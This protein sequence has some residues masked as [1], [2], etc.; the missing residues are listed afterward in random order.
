MKNQNIDSLIRDEIVLT[1]DEIKRLREGVKELIAAKSESNEELPDISSFE[2]AF[3]NYGDSDIGL[4]TRIKQ[5]FDTSSS[6]TSSLSSSGSVLPSGVSD[7]YVSPTDSSIAK[8]LGEHGILNSLD[9]IKQNSLD[10]SNSNYSKLSQAVANLD[11]FVNKTIPKSFVS[12]ITHDDD[13]IFISAWRLLNKN[14]FN[15]PRGYQQL[16]EFS[17]NSLD[18]I[19]EN[20]VNLNLT[21]S[22]ISLVST[23]LTYRMILK[24]YTKCAY[25]TQTMGQDKLVMDTA[26]MTARAREVRFFA[27]VCAP[28]IVFPLY[29]IG[30]LVG[31]KLSVSVDTSPIFEGLASLSPAEG[32][33]LQ[34]DAASFSDMKSSSPPCGFLM[35]FR[36]INNKFKW[37][38][39]LLIFIS[40]IFIHINSTTQAI[41]AG[42]FYYL[43]LNMYW[44]KYVSIL[45]MYIW[46]VFYIL[47][48]IKY[49][50]F[51]EIKFDNPPKY[52]PRFILTRIEDFNKQSEIKED[53]EYYVKVYTR[54]VLFILGLSILQTFLILY[55]L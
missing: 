10:L 46:V 5:Y 11:S 37:L 7:V 1:P 12:K 22:T 42:I 15:P 43:H 20:A 50:F 34:S 31:P 8:F 54:T 14:D 48:L 13:N 3:P 38:K 17:K 35:F 19:K 28:M 36:N 24:A 16:L 18:L 2:E 6:H 49:R 25:P 55:F 47:I 23:A 52:L 40:F 45:W 9:I 30:C 32:S 33:S 27:L 53:Q 4:I 39:Y 29:T 51:F 21:A 44:I 41:L 26:K